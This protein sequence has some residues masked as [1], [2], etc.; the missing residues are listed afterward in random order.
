MGFSFIRGDDPDQVFLLPPDAREWLPE[1]HLAWR[2]LRV[3]GE[4]DLD[5][6]LAGYRA[7]GRS[8]PAYHPGSMLA[9]VMYCYCKGIRSSRAIEAA[10]F[11]D[12]GARVI[13]GNRQPDHATI[14]R[15]VTRHAGAVKQLLVQTLV[16][17][18]SDGLLRV[19][20]V[21]GDGTVVKANAS[22][23]ANATAEQL[24]IDIAQLQEQIDAEVESW[25][26]Q[27]AAEDAAEDALFAH[28]DDDDDDG[29]PAAGGPGS[30]T[31][32]VGALLRRREA[33]T[34]LEQRETEHRAQVEAE[35]QARVDQRAARL[36]ER[37]QKLAAARAAYQAKVDDWHARAAAGP[38]PGTRPVPVEEHSTVRAAQ[39]SLAKATHALAQAQAAAAAPILDPDKA[40]RVNAT[41]PASR[42]VPGK[43]SGG[44]LQGYNLQAVATKNQ[45]I[46][47]IATH[48]S[49]NDTAALHPNLQAARANLDAAGITEAIGVALFDAGY[50]S[51]TNFTTPCPDPETTLLVAVNK[52]ARQTGR[53]TDHP[54]RV[55]GANIESWQQMTA[56]LDT[57]EGKTLYKKR[58]AIIEPVFAQLINRLG[59]WL[60]YRGD[61]VDTE[62]HLWAATHNLGKII[63]SR[64]ANLAAVPAAA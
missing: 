10:T 51:H 7:D 6:F 42:T 1:G 59:R 57:D 54:T 33:K 9:L 12:L 18:A 5:P 34:R 8:R 41:D 39:D 19:D 25:F 2:L 37:E 60:N 45:L 30:L 63:K 24:G 49:P 62:L 55:K 11:D 36:V 50:A 28:H 13:M 52:E 4:V 64:A 56:R 23:A 21:A 53:R 38:V 20:V 16:I 48:D 61:H 58:A 14:A 32:T 44:F 40:L 22:A 46:L 47:A 17:A 35:R 29:D 3:A 43:N 27:A 31:H 15:F 26:A